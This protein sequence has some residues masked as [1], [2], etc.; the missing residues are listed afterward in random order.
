MTRFDRLIGLG[1]A[2]VACALLLI[3]YPTHPPVPTPT[4]VPVAQAWPHARSGVI[5]DG[6]AYRPG[7]F[8]DAQTSVGTEPGKGVL[9][10]VLRGPGATVR[11]LRQLPSTDTPTFGNFTATGD[12]LAW[13]E[14]VNGGQLRLWTVNLRD[15]RP[16]RALTGN[17]GDPVFDG[18]QYDLEIANGRV[19]W[20]GVDPADRGVTEI[21]S[22]ALTGGAV[23]VRT[24]PGAWELSAWPW[25]VN[26]RD[27]AGGTTALH[28][29]VTGADRPVSTTGPHT[30]RCSPTWC[31]VVTL[32]GN[33]SRVELMHPD[34]T[35]RQTIAD[36]TT[37]PTIA[38]VAPLDRFEVLSQIDPYSDL[39][40]TKQVVVFDLATQRSVAIT[41]G[42]RTISYGNGVLWW[43]TGTV[44]APVWHSL[45]LRTV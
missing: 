44:D 3:A 23:N 4:P 8:L 27:T 7:I 40:A 26:G 19:Y 31:Q 16:P 35:A 18:S 37:L 2:L 24:E 14:G 33:G 39:T 20:A 32:S 36:G 34:G 45:D 10:L 41:S 17:L 43:S 28:N 5:A 42:A 1:A 13:A 30:T 38:N 15:G 6:S 21:R 9:R 25:L 12:D 22:V 11:V 29:L